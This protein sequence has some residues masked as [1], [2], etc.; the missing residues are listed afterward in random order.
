MRHFLFVGGNK[1]TVDRCTVA[2]DGA[3]EHLFSWLKDSQPALCCSL[4]KETPSSFD[5]SASSFDVKNSSACCLVLHLNPRWSNRLLLL[6]RHYLVQLYS[7]LA[8]ANEMGGFQDGVEMALQTLE[9][10][11]TKLPFRLLARCQRI[12]H[13]FQGIWHTISSLSWMPFS[14]GIICQVKPT[15]VETGGRAIIRIKNLID[16]VGS[17]KVCSNKN[18]LD[19]SMQPCC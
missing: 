13:K 2:T 9:I 12:T 6:K 17:A 19:T 3:S 14:S 11:E 8:K 15:R 10:S 18:K 5:K 16:E 7:H 1:S 4:N